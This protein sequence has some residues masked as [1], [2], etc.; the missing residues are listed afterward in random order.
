MSDKARDDDGLIFRPG[1]PGDSAGLLAVHRESILRLGIQAYS[2]RETESWAA[3]LT[4]EGYVRA[5]IEGGEHFFVAVHPREG[6]VAFCSYKGAEVM[7]LY[8]HPNWV[9]RGIARRLLRLAEVAIAAA[10][11]GEIKIIATLVGRPFYEGQGYAVVDNHDWQ[12]RG[13]LVI[14]ALAMHKAVG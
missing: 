7:A 10:G 6:V 12:T 14:E 9:R 3:K 8:V 11:H 1:E 2:R 5:M 13:G 4:A